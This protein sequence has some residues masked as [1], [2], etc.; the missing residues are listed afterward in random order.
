MQE[1]FRVNAGTR[2]AFTAKKWIGVTN[3]GRRAGTLVKQ[4]RPWNKDVN[5]EMMN[6]SGG[7]ANLC[8]I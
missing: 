6:G 7:R 5:N 3:G 4:A 2:P 8:S 1:V